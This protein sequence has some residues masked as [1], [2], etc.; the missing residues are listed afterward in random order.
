MATSKRFIEAAEHT[1]AC[2]ICF[3]FFVDPHIPKDLRCPHTCCQVCLQNLVFLNP[4]QS[5][6]CPMC[7]EETRIPK[8]GVSKLRTNLHVKNLAE[9]HPSNNT[10][11]AQPTTVPKCDTHKEKTTDTEKEMESCQKKMLELDKVSD[12]ILT[13]LEVEKQK[14]IRSRDA[15][16]QAVENESEIL[17]AELQEASYVSLN[18]IRRERSR[19]EHRA[20]ALRAAYDVG[21]FTDGTCRCH[22]CKTQQTQPREN[23]CQKEPDVPTITSSQRAARFVKGYPDSNL[24]KVFRAARLNLVQEFGHFQSASGIAASEDGLLAV[25]DRES[26]VVLFFNKKEN[27]KYDKKLLMDLKAKDST[28]ELQH[29]S[30]KGRKPYDIVF[31]HNG[32]IWLARQVQ[33][34]AFSRAGK[35]QSKI[36]TWGARDAFNPL[37]FFGVAGVCSLEVTQNGNKI[38]VGDSQRNVI[39]VHDAWNQ[40][41]NPLNPGS[42]IKTIKTS[43]KPCKMT[44]I[45]DTHVAIAHWKPAPGKVNVISLETEKETLSIDVEFVDAICYDEFTDCLFTGRPATKNNNKEL[46]FG[47]GVIEQY[48]WKTGT[49]IACIVQG[50]YHPAGMTV[51]SDGLLAVADTKSVKIYQIE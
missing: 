10:N 31:H 43:I 51:T 44:V 38:L 27:G 16:L 34:L 29:S 11:N 26:M 39:T 32:E 17:Q 45:Q 46:D 42:V 18:E 7:K 6:R 4:G 14:I 23:L 36:H 48:C 25:S 22:T 1:L 19:L 20:S 35:A 3:E 21:K 13:E 24:G 8:G 47:A 37:N 5:I 15:L 33:L 28:G 9:E 41:W 40:G 30:G 50:L 49:K 12:V 2:P